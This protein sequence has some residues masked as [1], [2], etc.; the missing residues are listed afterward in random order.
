[1]RL[2]RCEWVLPDGS[3]PP[4]EDDVP[5]LRY[6]EVTH[7][8][9]MGPVVEYF[10]QADLGWNGA[11]GDDSQVCMAMLAMFEPVFLIDA[12]GVVVRPRVCCTDR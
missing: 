10:S 5:T 2:V 9:D 6:R 7:D 1:M 12:A 3:G 11:A 8:G 4:P